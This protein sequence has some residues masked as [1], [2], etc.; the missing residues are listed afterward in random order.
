MPVTLVVG[1]QWGDEGKAKIIDYLAREVDF[2]VRFQGGANAGHTVVV[3]EKRFAFHQ[4]PSGILYPQT[5]CVL[6]GGMVIDP[7]ALVREIDGLAEQGVDFAGRIHISDQAHLVLPY[8]IALD[9]DSED[10]R[11][12]GG[13]GTTRKGISPAYADKARRDGVRMADLRRSPAQL[14]E[15]VTARVRENNRLLK[16][17]GA[18]TLSPA[19]V[20]DDLLSARRRLLPM[21]TD[22]RPILWA[23]EAAGKSVLC[24]GAQGS[25][26]DID[27]GTYPF[28]TSSSCSAGGAAIGTGLPPSAFGRIV[29]IF[30]AYCTRVGNG[31]FPTE[32]KGAPGRR[33]REIG[34]E[35]GT[36]TGRPRRCGWFDAVAARTVVQINGITDIALTKLDVLDSFAEVKVCT[37]YRAGKRSV[38]VFP[39]D[40]RD[41][42]AVRPHYEVIRG[43]EARTEGKQ[44]E[45]LPP[46]AIAYIRRL[47]Q[48]VGCRIHLVS[49]GPERSAMVEMPLARGAAAGL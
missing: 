5:A 1:G 37:S 16:L 8:H 44:L 6:G 7:S 18:K 48:L 42:A 21:I 10:R 14:R 20:V 47:E 23:A 39:A 24:E 32:D 25:L 36:T 4:V 17:R 12:D 13:I 11:V 34:R 46:R 35:Y 2:V 45:D 43:W 30:K 33:L 41:V 19:R 31:P 38:D 27:H 22:T 9:C 3:G 28:V 40:A 26:L 29:G 15:L 49:L